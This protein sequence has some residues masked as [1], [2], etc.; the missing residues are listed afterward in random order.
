MRRLAACALSLSL[1]GCAVPST[2]P[3]GESYTEQALGLP[4][5]FVAG[6][7]FDRGNAEGGDD[8]ERP[9][10]PVT[11]TGFYLG[12]TEVTQAQWLAV[13][14]SNS[15]AVQDPLRPVTN[16]SWF[17]VQEFLG[18]L[19]EKTG[20]VY[21]L[22]TEAEW[23]FA[24]RSGGKAERW[25]GTSDRGALREFAWF[26]E[27]SGGQVQPVGQKRPNGQGLY[28][29]AGNVIEWVEDWYGRYP[30]GPH[31]DPIGPETGKQKVV[32]D[33]SFATVVADGLRAALRDSIAPDTRS[34]EIGFRL[35][36]SLQ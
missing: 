3:R 18:K 4:M 7:T 20:K 22:P 29:M 23:E 27:T 5:V 14:G 12:K 11:L 1:L 26:G 2:L 17:E 6:G 8:D 24:A 9:V 15:S 21:R 35:A 31:T 16:V 33:G 32:R 25:A 28:D 36:R 10:T 30:G 13:M 19:R 34:P